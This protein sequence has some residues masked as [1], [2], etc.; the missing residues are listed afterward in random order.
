MTTGTATAPPACVTTSPLRKQGSL[1]LRLGALDDE[2]DLSAIER[3][4]VQCSGRAKFTPT[5]RKAKVSREGRPAPRAPLPFKLAA[6]DDCNPHGLHQGDMDGWAHAEPPPPFGIAGAGLGGCL[7]ALVAA[8][9][10]EKVE[11]YEY[12]ED[13]RKTHSKAGRSINL[14][15]TTRGL[16][17]LAK[18]GL[19]ERVQKIGVR[20][21]GSC[22]ALRRWRSA[23]LSTPGQ[24]LALES[25]LSS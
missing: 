12:R 20:L 3:Y 13:P 25:S 9:K 5:P 22:D 21:T 6:L 1:R 23:A 7:A 2:D 24:A 14:T 15:L 8:Q 10:G 16:S 19:E 18:F 17:C 4:R 11:V